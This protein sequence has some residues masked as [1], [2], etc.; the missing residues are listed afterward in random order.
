MAYVLGVDAMRDAVV[1]MLVKAWDP[2]HGIRL[3]L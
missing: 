2:V 1:I 3:R